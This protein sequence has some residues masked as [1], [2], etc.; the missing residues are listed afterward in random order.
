MVLWRSG[1]GGVVLMSEVPLE[2]GLALPQVI[3]A[4]HYMHFV[5]DS[6]RTSKFKEQSV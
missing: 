4:P 3:K 1:G 2:H 5:Q 6:L